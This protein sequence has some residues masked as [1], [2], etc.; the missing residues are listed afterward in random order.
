MSIYVYH[1]NRALMTAASTNTNEKSNFNLSWK[2]S[3]MA[4]L[5][6]PKHRLIWNDE[7]IAELKK[8]LSRLQKQ[9][10]SERF[11]CRFMSLFW[12]ERLKKFTSSLKRAQPVVRLHRFFV[13][14]AKNRWEKR[15]LTVKH[16]SF[17]SWVVEIAGLT[18]CLR[19]S[20]RSFSVALSN[21]WAYVSQC[22]L[23]N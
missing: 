13:F 4:R 1:A 6:T 15:K 10:N 11:T 19:N 17:P 14:E 3:F 23:D 21:P 20:E 16:T 8:F 18:N 7:G 2:L 12:G 22:K 5:V 9:A